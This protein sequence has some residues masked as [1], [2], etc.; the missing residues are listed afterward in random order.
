MIYERLL[1]EL[2]DQTEEA[3]RGGNEKVRARH[4][5]RGKLP[6][7]DRIDKLLDPGTVF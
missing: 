4:E 6:V 1:E 7:R 3:R 5:E 2:R